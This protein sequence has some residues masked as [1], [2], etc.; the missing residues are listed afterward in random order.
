MTLREVA[1]YD[2]P[3]QKGPCV[4]AAGTFRDD[5]EITGERL[6]TPVNVVLGLLRYLYLALLILFTLYLIWLIRRDVERK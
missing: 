4:A 6:G 2:A 3:T 5:E 1:C